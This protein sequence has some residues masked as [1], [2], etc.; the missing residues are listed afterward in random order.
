MV[1]F[2]CLPPR[3]LI[4]HVVPRAQKGMSTWTNCVLACVDCNSKTA[5]RTPV[6]ARMKLRKEPARHAW[7]PCSVS[8]HS[9]K[10]RSKIRQYQSRLSSVGKPTK[11]KSTGSNLLFA[12]GISCRRKRNSIRSLSEQIKLTI[13][14]RVIEH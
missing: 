9:G 7:K 12:F 4:D 3:W 14:T 8:G 13:R 6:R 10:T 5:D 1:Q 2:S 11:S